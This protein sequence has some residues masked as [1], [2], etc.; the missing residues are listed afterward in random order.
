MLTIALVVQS[1]S[2][3]SKAVLMNMYL[4]LVT[5]ETSQPLSGW[6]Y[7]VQKSNIRSIVTTAPVSQE[8][9]FILNCG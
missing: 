9:I 1:A 6:L 3:W 2:G 5:D 8:L 7:E 4:M